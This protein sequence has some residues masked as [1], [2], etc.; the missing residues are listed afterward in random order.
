MFPSSIPSWMTT[1]DASLYAGTFIMPALAYSMFITAAAMT[2]GGSKITPKDIIA[3]VIIPGAWYIFF[4]LLLPLRTALNINEKF[5]MHTFLIAVIISTL[6]FLFF[7][8]RILIII[9]KKNIKNIRPLFWKIPIALIFPL[10]GLFI[11]SGDGLPIFGNFGHPLFFI[12]AAVNGILLCLPAFGSSC[13]RLA[14]F[15]GRCLTFSYT[16]YFFIVFLPYL[17]LSLV[18]VLAAGAGLLMLT[19]VLL[20]MLHSNEL[21]KDFTF[22]KNFFPSKTL[23]AAAL[24]AFLVI[25]ACITANYMLDRAALNKALAYVYSPD[26]SAVYDIDDINKKSL[27][28]T[29]AKVTDNKKE[30]SLFFGSMTAPYLT[31]YFNWLVLDNLTLSDSKINTI[32]RVFFGEKALRKQAEETRDRDIKI[33]SINTNSTYDDLQRAWI[34][35]IDIEITSA[36]AL[37]FGEYSTN[38]ELPDGCWI[39]GYYLYVGDKKEYG[40]LAEKKSAMWIF[41]QIRGENRDPGILYYK[42]GNRIV[43]KVFPFAKNE[44]RKTGIELL[45][46]DPVR[47]TIDDRTLHLGNEM[48]ADKNK[49]ITET[50]S[51]A[52]ISAKDKRALPAV[53]RRP[54]FHFMIDVSVGKKEN[55]DEFTKMIEQSISSRPDLAENACVSFVNTSVSTQPL[56]SNWKELWPK[57]NF[58]G[59]FYLDRAVKSALFAAWNEGRDSYPVIISVTDSIPDAIIEND[60]SDFKMAFPES[61][62]FFFLNSK[63]ELRPHSLISEPLKEALRAPAIGF[64]PQVLE[65]TLA[66]GQKTYL[67]NDGKPGIIL[68]KDMF[69]T[70]AA[71]EKNWLRGLDLQGKW[72][73]H[74]MHPEKAEKEWVALVRDSFASQIMTP[75]TSYLVVE[76]EA[77]KAALKKKQEAVLSAGKPLDAGEE[78]R[79]M[80]EPNAITLVLLALIFFFCKIR[81]HPRLPNKPVIVTPK[82]QK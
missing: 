10:L 23:K 29:L 61:D 3:A 48:N 9:S 43:F 31:S 7:I 45:H 65:Y 46:K 52:Y 20:F 47:L 11:N 1:L 33:K 73:S 19:P 39:S 77:Q 42:T 24:A 62:F 34:S 80:A 58:E 17:P 28:K 51:V 72:L 49:N 53:K 69:D 56:N 66:D 37:N 21:Y 25:P 15:A 54:Y 12:I 6:L 71:A 5:L 59:G 38:F 67:P 60:F 22:L 74:V 50:E 81:F 75:A 35:R 64:E 63:G 79:V 26:Y 57:Q 16:L 14:L 40:I 27:K 55:I 78:T 76:N 82:M 8:V 2:R 70:S 4:I 30:H 41:S 32:E 36:F 44:T 13:G 68:K 18:A